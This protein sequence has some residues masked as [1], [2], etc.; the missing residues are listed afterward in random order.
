[1]LQFTVQQLTREQLASAW[2]LVRAGGAI[3]DLDRWLEA[4]RR[5]LGNGGGILAVATGE[6][7]LHGVA[8]YE[9]VEEVAAGKVLQV[10]TFVTFELSRRAPVRAVLCDALERLGAALGCDAVSVSADN[11]GFLAEMRE[12]GQAASDSPA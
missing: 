8:T 1:M 12:R 5:L 2:P 7:A 11:R 6:G 4:G 9:T 10:D 3:L